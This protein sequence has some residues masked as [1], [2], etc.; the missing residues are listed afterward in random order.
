MLKGKVAIVTGSGNGIGRG[1]AL[2]LAEKGAQVVVNDIDEPAVGYLTVRRPSKKGCKGVEGDLP[3][4]FHL[5][6]L[7]EFPS[8]TLD[9]FHGPPPLYE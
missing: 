8:F 1:I 6:F 9:V 2:K 7:P 4:F 3:S 5:L